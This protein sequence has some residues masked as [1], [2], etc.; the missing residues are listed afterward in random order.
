LEDIPVITMEA[1]SS[2][3]NSSASTLFDKSSNEPRQQWLSGATLAML[4]TLLLSSIG[5]FVL[6]GLVLGNTFDVKGQCAS[7][8]FVL[9]AVRDPLAPLSTDGRCTDTLCSQF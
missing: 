2:S 1:K 7:Q 3:H 6:S 4:S 9:F 5:G 8:S